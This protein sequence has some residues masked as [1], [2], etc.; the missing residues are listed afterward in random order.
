MDPK[1]LS[2][3]IR[4]L[5]A[6]SFFCD[7]HQR[8]LFQDAVSDHFAKRFQLMYVDSSNYDE[9]P[10]KVSISGD[11]WLP[12]SVSNSAEAVEIA[13]SKQ[14]DALTGN[15]LSPG[16]VAKLL[17]FQDRFGM[18]LEIQGQLTLIVGVSLNDVLALERN[19]GEVLRSALAWHTGVTPS[20]ET[21][22]RRVRAT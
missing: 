19:T 13:I 7:R 1:T 15:L 14:M 21:F 5:G 6:A 4:K 17:Q 2:G 12:N 11:A 3:R 22:A 9:T 10:M 20:C 18:L 8:R 16:M